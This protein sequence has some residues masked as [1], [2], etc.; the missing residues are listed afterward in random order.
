MLVPVDDEEP[1]SLERDER[2]VSFLVHVVGLP[3]ALPPDE[4]RR[5]QLLAR[6]APGRAAPFEGDEVDDVHTPSLEA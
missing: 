6:S 3:L 2:N 1:G 5:V 4:E